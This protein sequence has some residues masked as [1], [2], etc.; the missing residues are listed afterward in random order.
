MRLK[1]LFR[2]SIFE[3]ALK[4]NDFETTAYKLYS[5]NIKLSQLPSTI[6][7]MLAETCRQNL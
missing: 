4:K 2:R 7:C 1:I 3:K 5:E 6:L